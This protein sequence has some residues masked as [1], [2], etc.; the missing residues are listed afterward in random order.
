MQYSIG[1]SSFADFLESDSANASIL[2][3]EDGRVSDRLLLW[4]HKLFQLGMDGAVLVHVLE[5]W[6]LDIQVCVGNT[7][8]VLG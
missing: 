1:F 2:D 4:A 6:G 3:E 7:I 8:V 5:D